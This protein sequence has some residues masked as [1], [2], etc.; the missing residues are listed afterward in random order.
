MS[1]ENFVSADIYLLPYRIRG[2]AAYVMNGYIV[3][4]LYILS[5]LQYLLTYYN[6]DKEIYYKQINAN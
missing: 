5:F 4:T 3:Y 1:F 2:Y 6:I